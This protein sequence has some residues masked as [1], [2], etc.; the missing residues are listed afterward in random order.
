MKSRA[1]PAVRNGYL[2]VRG[3]KVKPPK[4]RLLALVVKDEGTECW[5]WQGSLSDKNNPLRHYGKLVI[6]SR[7]DGTRKT[8]RAHRYAYQVFIG[9]VPQELFVCHKCDNP[10][11]INPEHLFLGTRQDNVDDRE[12]KGRNKLPH[13]KPQSPK[14][15]SE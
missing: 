13:K 8:V 9:E 3:Q 15:E 14:Q 10:K 11:C 2:Y 5:N 12:A 7:K 1:K 4:E 6:G